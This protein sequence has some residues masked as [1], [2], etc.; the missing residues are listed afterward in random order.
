MAIASTGVVSGGVI[1]ASQRLQPS[2]R[3]K[4]IRMRSRGALPRTSEP[5]TRRRSLAQARCVPKAFVMAL[6]RFNV[7]VSW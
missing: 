7:P 4:A 6:S 1:A 5:K 2:V 3:P